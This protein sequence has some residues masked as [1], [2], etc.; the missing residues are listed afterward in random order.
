M[1]CIYT[2][3]FSSYLHPSTLQVH[4]SRWIE[5][6]LGHSLGL[7]GGFAHPFGDTNERKQNRN[8][9]RVCLRFSNEEGICEYSGVPQEYNRC[10][11][12]HSS[13]E[14]EEWNQ[15]VSYRRAKLRISQQN[16]A[17]DFTY[18][19]ITEFRSEIPGAEVTCDRSLE[20]HLTEKTES[21]TWNFH[22]EV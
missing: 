16:S 13:D 4:I 17:A 20:V 19:N 12:A 3:T 18:Q 7:V 8:N 15:R 5:T 11:K 14:R 10:V 1:T 2:Q 6:Q 22:I 21:C 9:V